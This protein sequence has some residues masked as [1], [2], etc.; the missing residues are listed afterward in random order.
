[1]EL[2]ITPS[3]LAHCIYSEAIDLPSI[4][5]LEIRRA[6]HVEPDGQGGWW[7]DL[8]PVRGPRLGPYP[9]RSRALEAEGRWLRE[10]WLT[11]P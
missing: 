7:A 8:S 11:K 10:H 6:S 9:T 4:G 2:V 5:P 3:G 1:M